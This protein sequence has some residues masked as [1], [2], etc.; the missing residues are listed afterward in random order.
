MSQPPTRRQIQA[1]GEQPFFYFCFFV[2]G[3]A[4]EGNALKVAEG[5]EPSSSSTE[6]SSKLR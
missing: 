1:T 6:A 3:K 4:T 2:G 5:R